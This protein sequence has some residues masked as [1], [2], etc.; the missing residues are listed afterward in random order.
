MWPDEPENYK[1]PSGLNMSIIIQQTIIMMRETLF[2]GKSTDDGHWVYGSLMVHGICR[3]ILPEYPVTPFGI[4]K[5]RVDPETVGQFTGLTDKNKIKLFE[6]DIIKWY[7]GKHYW[8]AI[9]QVL[10]NKE[11]INLYAVETFHNCTRDEETLLYTYERSDSRR[12]YKNDITYI[13]S[14]VEIIGNIH[15]NSKLLN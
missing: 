14:D 15:D 8:E 12:G 7:F 13:N 5:T 9:I 3:Y 4:L 6:G 2:R 11:S 10:S 1:T